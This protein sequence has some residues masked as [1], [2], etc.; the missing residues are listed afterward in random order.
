MDLGALGAVS[1]GPGARQ[2]Q[3]RRDVD[4]TEARESESDQNEWSV[5][6][7]GVSATRLDGLMVSV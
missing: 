1:W 6:V 3:V 2:G 7:C 5:I 4:L